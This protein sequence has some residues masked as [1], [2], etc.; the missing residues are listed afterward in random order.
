[1]KAMLITLTRWNMLLLAMFFSTTAS[2]KYDWHVRNTNEA[3]KTECSS[4]HMAY[5]PKWL[6]AEAWEKMMGRLDKHFG[7]NASVEPSVREEITAYLVKKAA[8]EHDGFN[9]SATL[10]VT[11]TPWFI[12]GHGR[13]AERLWGSRK[14]GNAAICT[15]C[16][17]GT[18]LD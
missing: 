6:S 5:M 7:T 13:N 15:S 4:C 11:D 2:A 3:W 17:Q 10:R 12:R 16:H 14:Q 8:S 9:S 18:L 1:M